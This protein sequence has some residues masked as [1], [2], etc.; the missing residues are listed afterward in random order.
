MDDPSPSRVKQLASRFEPQLSKVQRIASMFECEPPSPS[1][2]I[3]L[4]RRVGGNSTAKI[5]YKRVQSDRPS[6][7]GDS[8]QSVRRQ[9]IPSPRT[10][11]T[12]A[13]QYDPAEE[14]FGGGEQLTEEQLAEE[15]LDG[16]SMEEMEALCEIMALEESRAR[17]ERMEALGYEVAGGEGREEYRKE[18]DGGEGGWWQV[19]YSDGRAGGEGSGGGEAEGGGTGGV[20]GVAVVIGD[21]E[22]GD[23]KDGGSV[24]SLIRSI[25]G[26]PK[27][28]K[29]QPQPISPEKTPG[30][31]RKSSGGKKS[32]EKRRGEPGGAD[33]VA[34]AIE[35]FSG[36]G[37]DPE[38][39]STSRMTLS[40]SEPSLARAA[41]GATAGNRRYG[42]A[43]GGPLED[44]AVGMAGGG[45]GRSSAGLSGEFPL[46]LSS[47]PSVSVVDAEL[48]RKKTEVA[49]YETEL[50]RR[51][52]ELNRLRVELASVSVEKVQAEI[53]LTRLKQEVEDWSYVP[54]EGTGQGGNEADEAGET[55]ENGASDLKKDGDGGRSEES[56]SSAQLK[57]QLGKVR[58][59]NERLKR[60]EKSLT[61]DVEYI[62]TMLAQEKGESAALRRELAEVKQ[63]RKDLDKELSAAQKELS[64][65]RRSAAVAE[66]RAAAEEA[67]AALLRQQLQKAQAAEMGLL[68]QLQLA[69]KEAMGLRKTLVWSKETREDAE[70]W[71]RGLQGTL[72]E[73]VQRNGELEVKG[74][75]MMTRLLVLEKELA[76]EQ[77]RRSAAEFQ[78]R[79]A[80]A[81]KELLE[82]EVMLL[83]HTRGVIKDAM[84]QG[85]ADGEERRASSRAEDMVPSGGSAK[86]VSS[87]GLKMEVP[88]RVWDILDQVEETKARGMAERDE[89]TRLHW[90]TACVRGELHKARFAAIQ[91]AAST[92]PTA[93]TTNAT[94]TMGAA[95]ASSSPAPSLVPAAGL[96]KPLGK[97]VSKKLSL[98]LDLD[99]HAAAAAPADPAADSAASAASGTSVSGTTFST[100]ASTPRTPP[101]STIAASASA[102]A[103]A[104]SKF[105]RWFSHRSS[106][107]PAYSSAAT[108]AA[109]W[110]AGSMAAS[111]AVVAEEGSASPQAPDPV[112]RVA[113]D[114]SAPS[115]ALPSLLPAQSAPSTPAPAPAASAATA[116]TTPSGST[117]QPTN[118]RFPPR[119]HLAIPTALPQP[120]RV[121][122]WVRTSAIPNYKPPYASGCAAGFSCDTVGRNPAGYVWVPAPPCSYDRWRFNPKTFLETMRNKIVAFVGDSLSDNLHASVHCILSAYT[123]IEFKKSWLGGARPVGSLHAAQ[124]NFTL[125]SINSGY[126]VQSPRYYKDQTQPYVVNPKWAGILRYTHSII[127]SAGHWFFHPVCPMLSGSSTR[128]APCSLLFHPEKYE[129]RL[130]WLVPRFSATTAAAVAMAR[131]ERASASTALV[132]VAWMAGVATCIKVLLVPAYRSTD[133]EV[134]RNWLAITHSLPLSQ[135]YEDATSQW[136]LDYPPLFAFFERCLAL[137]ACRVDPL[138]THLVNGL[139]HASYAT[140]LFQRVSV[141]GTD[142]LL[143]VAAWR[144]TLG[145]PS[146]AHRNV[147]AGA[148][149]LSAGLLLVD[150]MH[151][152]Y[153][154]MLLAMLLLSLALLADGRHVWASLTF[155]S[156]CC[157]KHLFAVAGP[158]F[159]VFLLRHHCFPSPPA[160]A[161]PHTT[162]H[163]SSKPPRRISPGAKQQ[164]TSA[165][166]PGSSIPLLTSL[167]R[168]VT[169]GAV[170]VTV[171][172]VSF[173]PFVVTNQMP[174]LIAR[175]FPFG[176]GLMHAYWAPN[177][178]ALYTL[179]DKLLAAAASAA[180]SL[181]GSAGGPALGM[182][183]GWTRGLV[184]DA[185]GFSV[186]P[187]VTPLVSL[188]LVLGAM[189][190]VLLHIW[191]RPS[192]YICGAASDAADRDR[193]DRN[194]GE[195]DGGE[196]GGREGRGSE[197]YDTPTGERRRWSIQAI[198]A[199]LAH[200]FLSAFLLG[201]HVHEKA[202][203]HFLLPLSLLA[204]AS[205]AWASEFLI[206]ATGECMLL[207][208]LSLSQL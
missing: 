18:G 12:P 151:F 189:A 112:P 166:A 11:E 25:E 14:S 107:R 158:F 135:W 95:S 200:V 155:A 63:Q 31:S 4:S 56:S 154:G 170:V 97:A 78:A 182:K 199:A 43:N 197:P 103:S 20:E 164:S 163:N 142:C 114:E 149:V 93:T 159:L 85:G 2:A 186:V 89:L 153:N 17:A 139:E 83:R 169:L 45:A 55:G 136:T 121:R 115:T 29:Q 79:D 110:P 176:R 168:I 187:Q 113:T 109:A 54:A 148:V 94:T 65:L 181:I 143:A 100:T 124:Y 82:E 138:M 156:L 195:R 106:D 198:A 178:W 61:A 81:A 10:V 193:A 204:S 171:L 128:Y 146:R 126:I 1:T 36:S 62:E 48:S 64:S 174:N 52:A 6:P 194:V 137:L 69:T 102:S 53:A 71:E 120:L 175:L 37:K 179:A 118:V 185:V 130:W 207:A 131:K 90:L 191:L 67:D 38:R 24:G 119:S 161:A 141:M 72:A 44:R 96:A 150:H 101:H 147:A 201:W 77:Q 205:P 188:L 140:V 104:G 21:D 123:K 105:V 51:R 19:G 13:L 80:V 134:H 76:E 145:L 73:Q 108:S 202:V 15:G 116:A 192:A 173:A 157:F 7:T 196:K 88:A 5:Q 42:L 39:V 74:G 144:C 27:Q 208:L 165:S 75:E 183:G 162:T 99:Q 40:T 49:R 160:A 133:F 70:E 35:R 58:L 184:G 117:P 9:S 111:A 68:E 152:Q 127:F 23:S 129:T 87:D 125:L 3:S 84:L 91:A 190:P 98:V 132:D 57:A 92:N 33:T 41:A 50:A 16:M 206:L 46:E 86:V 26:L 30:K 177:F 32:R 60:R 47:S 8:Q 66:R 28:S 122:S 22:E 167:A 59:E 34:G 180:G 203:L 172:L